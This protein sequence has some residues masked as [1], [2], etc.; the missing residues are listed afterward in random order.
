MKRHVV[1]YDATCTLCQGL[2][3]MM[4]KLDCNQNVDWYPVQEVSNKTKRL[5][6]QFK[7][8]EKEIYL[9]SNAKTVYIGYNAIRKLLITIP[10]TRPIGIVLY[11][12]GARLIGQP[13]YRIVSNRRHRWFKTLPY[14]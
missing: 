1:F 5:A 11:I 9:L 12:P 6:A 8:M 2:K 13:V 4:K 14:K 10:I 3:R 7:D